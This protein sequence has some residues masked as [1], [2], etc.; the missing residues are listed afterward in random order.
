VVGLLR[1][2]GKCI[3][4]YQV[5]LVGPTQAFAAV[6]TGDDQPLQSSHDVHSEKAL[7]G[8]FLMCIGVASAHVL[9]SLQ[10]KFGH[11]QLKLP[12]TTLLSILG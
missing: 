8:R 5:D 11:W 3:M 1:Q 9:C 4:S 2:C 12:I 6:S 7:E 10:P